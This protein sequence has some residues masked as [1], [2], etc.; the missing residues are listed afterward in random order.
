MSDDRPVREGG[1][2]TVAI[3]S[4]PDKLD[5]SPGSTLVGRTVFARP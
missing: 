1:T 3:E 2:L 4:D 5:P